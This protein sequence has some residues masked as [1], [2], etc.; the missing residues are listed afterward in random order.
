MNP[1]MDEPSKLTPSAKARG[2]L[3]GE[4]GDIFLV[5]E[6]IAERQFGKL[7]VV[8]LNKIEN[9]LCGA[10]H[11]GPPVKPSPRGSHILERPTLCEAGLP[12]LV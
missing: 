9:V 7:D 11:R 8:V 1:A 6:D 4:E 2:Q 5:A 3:T 12:E 10:F